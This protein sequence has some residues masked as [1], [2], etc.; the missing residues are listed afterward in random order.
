MGPLFNFA[1]SSTC[2]SVF[3]IIPNTPK[4]YSTPI[5]PNNINYECYFLSSYWLVL[6][7]QMLDIIIFSRNMWRYRG[8]WCTSKENAVQGVHCLNGHITHFI[9][10]YSICYPWQKHGPP[11]M[12]HIYIYTECLKANVVNTEVSV[13]YVKRH[14]M[15]NVWN[16]LTIISYNIK[17]CWITKNNAVNI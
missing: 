15:F 14:K 9:N 10:K 3:E 16:I 13:C 6:M 8:T 17:E 4:W 12:K 11:S 1:C 5:Y 2:Y 7:Q